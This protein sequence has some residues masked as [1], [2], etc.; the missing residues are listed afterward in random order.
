MKKTLAI[1]ALVEADTKDKT[2]KIMYAIH[3]HVQMEVLVMLKMEMRFVHVQ[4]VFLEKS[5]NL[6]AHVLHNLV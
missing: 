1:H 2:V 6:Q 3:C 4:M 5:V